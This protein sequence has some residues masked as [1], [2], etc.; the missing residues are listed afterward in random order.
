MVP[1]VEDFSN[2]RIAQVADIGQLRVAAMRLCVIDEL[3]VVGVREQCPGLVEDNRRAVLAG[4][5]RVDKVAKRAE[6]EVRGYHTA[7]GT[8]QRRT[9]RDHRRTWC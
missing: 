8:A 5:L 7:R 3:L 6:L 9:Q 4:A 2:Q 1:P